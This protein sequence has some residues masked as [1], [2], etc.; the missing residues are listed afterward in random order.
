MSGLIKNVMKFEARMDVS[1]KTEISVFL[2]FIENQSRGCARCELRKAE[3]FDGWVVEC[4]W[5][6][7]ESMRTH[8]QSAPLQ[9]LIWV[10]A[11]RSSSIRFQSMVGAVAGAYQA[12]ADGLIKNPR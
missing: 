8:F 7:E 12:P 5:S 2:S 6:D 11:C 9:D 4:N 1:L 10:I 3:G